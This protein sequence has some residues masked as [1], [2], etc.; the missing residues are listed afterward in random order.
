MNKLILLAIVFGIASAYEWDCDIY[1]DEDCNPELPGQ[2]GRTKI[3]FW[4]W[5]GALSWLR[6]FDMFQ[7]FVYFPMAIAWT[8]MHRGN[9]SHKGAFDFLSS[10]KW[11]GIVGWIAA[12]LNITTGVFVMTDNGDKIGWDRTRTNWGD[13]RRRNTGIGLIVTEIIG[14]G[15]YYFF[16]NGARMYA[17]DELVSKQPYSE[18]EEIDGAGF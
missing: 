16:R 6:T 18:S 5:F 10:W 1:N 2:E 11:G 13:R 14:Q 12:A 9:A 15:L 3:W 7:F 17:K 4:R 8:R